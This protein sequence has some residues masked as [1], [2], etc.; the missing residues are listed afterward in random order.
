MYQQLKSKS[1]SSMQKYMKKDESEGDKMTV[2]HLLVMLLRYSVLNCFFLDS[3]LYFLDIFYFYESVVHMF[4]IS[5]VNVV[6]FFRVIGTWLLT[7]YKTYYFCDNV[8]L[9][10]INHVAH[11]TY[12]NSYKKRLFFFITVKITI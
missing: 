3:I 11:L 12:A 2:S 8:F 10:I 4:F 7:I 6:Q 5:S 9:Y 1:K